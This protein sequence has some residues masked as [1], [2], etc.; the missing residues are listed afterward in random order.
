MDY[1]PT[2]LI[3]LGT[4]RRRRESATDRERPEL[5][6]EIRAAAGAGMAQAE[7]VAITGYSRESVRLLC[8]TP[9]QREAERAKRRQGDGKPKRWTAQS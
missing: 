6:K 5:E 8:M 2:N 1:D 3:R 7:I 9:E 4:N